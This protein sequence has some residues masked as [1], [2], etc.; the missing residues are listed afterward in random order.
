MRISTNARKQAL[1]QQK[2]YRYLQIIEKLAPIHAA[3]PGLAFRMAGHIIFFE[4]SL[5][6]PVFALD[7]MFLSGTAA[8]VRERSS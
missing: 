7:I 8:Q 3:L 2:F 4:N 1:L 6:V 5:R